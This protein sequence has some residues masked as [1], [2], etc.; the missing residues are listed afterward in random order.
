MQKFNKKRI[1]IAP[2]DWG[3][4]H[5]TRCISIIRH[6]LDNECSVIVACNNA[7]KS[8][9][10]N[11]FPGIKF[12]PLE[13]YNIRYSEA[14]WLLPFKLM[15]QFP[16]IA[17]AIAKEHYWLQKTIEKHQIDVVISDN[18]YGLCSTKVPSIFITH[19]LTIKAPFAW[20]EYLLQRINY[21]YINKFTECWV[22]DYAGEKNIAGLL[23]HPRQMPKVSVQYIG[24][25]ARFKKSIEPK[26]TYYSYCIILSGPEPQRTVLEN[27]ILGQLAII[28]QD[29]LLVRGKPNAAPIGI[30]LPNVVVH[31]H[32]HGQELQEA[33]EASEYIIARSGYTSVMELLALQKKMILIP[34][35]G[36]TEQEYL[37]HQ[38]M[39]QHW[40]YCARQK[41][42]DLRKAMAAA[43]M[44]E[45]KLPNKEA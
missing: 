2:L 10:T 20:L 30:N 3:L 29:C 12:L 44:F 11:E 7:Q 13:G 16:K 40:A 28:T 38:L 45:Y 14:Q 34:T 27:I 33:I 22:P 36:Q 41:G 23:S 42:F 6:L 25:L 1:L 4:G 39:S 31:N 9:L 35:P 8:I 19:Q 37:S 5:T 21:S 17:I 18:R 43:R 32:L 26:P 24:P 15:A